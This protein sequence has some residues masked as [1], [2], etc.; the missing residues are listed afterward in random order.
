MCFLHSDG[1]MTGVFIG[2]YEANLAVSKF[3]VL[4][5]FFACFCVVFIGI[6][7]VSIRQYRRSKATTRERA[8]AKDRASKEA[9]P[10]QG[11]QLPLEIDVNLQSDEDASSRV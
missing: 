8:R 6:V 3:Q 2:L 10:S 7:I 4:W 9:T 5:A 1:I 11:A